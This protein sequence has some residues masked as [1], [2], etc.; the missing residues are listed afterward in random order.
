M[1][2]SGVDVEQDVKT[3]AEIKGDKV[4]VQ[5]TTLSVTDHAYDDILIMNSTSNY[6]TTGNYG[7]SDTCC[8]CTT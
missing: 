4:A 6:Y 1:A 3:E 8:E 5:V 2:D 7:Q